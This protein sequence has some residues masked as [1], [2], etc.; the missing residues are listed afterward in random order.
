M[1]AGLPADASVRYCQLPTFQP[2]TYTAGG[3]GALAKPPWVLVT[4]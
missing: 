1:P 4:S 2:S 3:P